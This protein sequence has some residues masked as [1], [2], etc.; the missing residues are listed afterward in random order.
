MWNL[1]AA[2][3]G[4]FLLIISGIPADFMG[5]GKSGVR[6]RRIR[7]HESIHRAEI[8]TKI[9]LPSPPYSGDKG[10]GVRGMSDVESVIDV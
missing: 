3:T 4:Q 7:A 8:N 2:D 5:W 10:M 9:H 1:T 6:H